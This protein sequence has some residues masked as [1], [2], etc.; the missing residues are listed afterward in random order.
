MCKKERHDSK[1]FTQ[2]LV[3]T[4]ATPLFPLAMFIRLSNENSKNSRIVFRTSHSSHVNTKIFDECCI[5]NEVIHRKSFFEKFY[6]NENLSE[7]FFEMCRI[8]N[9]ISWFDFVVVFD[10]YVHNWVSDWQASFNSM[11]MTLV[12]K[13]ISK[14]INLFIKWACRIYTTRARTHTH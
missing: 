13:R 2:L 11:V 6:I 4:R 5:L 3:S 12:L 8:C 7:G 10:E 14:E 1:K 9:S